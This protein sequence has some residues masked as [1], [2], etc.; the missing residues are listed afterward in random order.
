MDIKK[1][2]ACVL[3]C[4]IVG[5]AG[6]LFVAPAIRGW[7]AGLT[8]PFYNPPN[9]VFAPVWSLLFALMGFAIYLVLR[10]GWKNGRVR[11][12]AQFF[13][14]QFGLNILWSVLFFGSR[15][16]RLAFV[17]II[18]LWLAIAAT[19]SVFWRLSKPAAWLMLPYF[20]WVTFAA[21]LNFSIW[22]LNN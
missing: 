16:P 22:R 17:E 10:R 20:L 19:I 21:V 4:E 9:W 7:Y 6:S 8:K 11:T 5:A 15:S 13:V 1:L 18:G 14:I 12:A 2:V 3:A